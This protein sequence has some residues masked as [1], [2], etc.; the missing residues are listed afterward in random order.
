[1]WLLTFAWHFHDNLKLSFMYFHSCASAWDAT[2]LSMMQ[3]FSN[4]V[5]L[6]CTLLFLLCYFFSPNIIIYNHFSVLRTCSSLQ[7]Y[8]YICISAY[9]MEFIA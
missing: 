3:Y 7:V 1:M 5:V 6:L 8:T 4:V 9:L 2:F